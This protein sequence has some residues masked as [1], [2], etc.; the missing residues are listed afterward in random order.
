[1]NKIKNLNIISSNYFNNFFLQRANANNILHFNHKVVGYLYT[2]IIASQNKN[3][4]QNNNTYIT[5]NQ[6]Y[7]EIL[8][9]S[10]FYSTKIEKL[11]N[12]S[13][14]KIANDELDLYNE[15][16]EA[17]GQSLDIDGFDLESSDG[18]LTL[19][20][21]KMGTYVIN[22]QSPNMQ[23]WWSSPISGPKRFDYSISK[24]LWV[25]NRDSTPMRDL[26]KKEIHHLCKYNLEI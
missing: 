18:V 1:M 6:K 9:I 8:S 22:K 12:N 19:K 13:Y 2:P 4:L 26:L 17:L 10:R 3:I 5:V 25:D 7:N 11:D 14:H 23:I 16:L 24:S 20:L 21:G 15:K